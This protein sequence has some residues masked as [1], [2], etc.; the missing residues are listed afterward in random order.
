MPMPQPI[1]ITPFDYGAIGDGVTNDTTALQNMASAANAFVSGAPDPFYIENPPQVYFPPCAGFVTTAP[2][3]LVGS[4]HLN[5]VSPIIVSPTVGAGASGRW[6]EMTNPWSSNP[7]GS[8]PRRV[9]WRVNMRRKTQSSWATE[10]DIGFYWD[11]AYEGDIYV[12]RIEGFAIG[13]DG[14][15]SYGRLFIGSTFGAKKGGKLSLRLNQFSNQLQII[16]GEFACGGY[17]S[18]MSRYGLE[19]IGKAPNGL[20]TIYMVGQSYELGFTTARTGNPGGEAIP[21]LLNGAEAPVSY[22]SARM[23]RMEG[24]G[25]FFAR[26][27]GK[28]YETAIG[29]LHSEAE[30]GFA[31]YALLDNQTTHC[32]ALQ[33]FKETGANG[34]DWQAIWD[35]GAIIENAVGFSGQGVAVRGLEAAIDN[36]AAAPTWRGYTLAGNTLFNSDGT[37]NGFTTGQLLG[38]RLALNGERTIS[39]EVD[40]AANSD[41]LLTIL[42]F[43]SSG[44]QIVSNNAVTQTF[45]GYNATLNRFGGAYQVG[46]LASN[47][48]SG[49]SATGFRDSI[50][51]A[52]NVA[53]IFVGIASK[54]RRFTIRAPHGRA[55]RIKGVLPSLD[56]IYAPSAPVQTANIPYVTGMAVDN[57]VPATGQP[58]GWVC[59][60]GATGTFLTTGSL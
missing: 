6:L 42:C 11:A 58:K 34:Q 2:I 37:M 4:V 60:N 40:K 26:A 38:V 20:N 41:L 19:L 59:T 32:S 8:G 39:V 48:S 47:P 16:G 57:I 24:C 22:V 52:P 23:Q 35:S 51:F 31:T 50:G 30:A 1:V 28:V 17:N 25:P 7:N 53:T 12:D 54:T 43:D 46:G 45:A 3:R 21:L 33:I 13:F 29:I 9:R 18:G 5:M 44:Q 10:N 55:R 14:C 36:G 27:T 49:Y 15:L 56:R